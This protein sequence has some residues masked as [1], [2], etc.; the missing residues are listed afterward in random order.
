VSILDP[1][2]AGDGLKRIS[3]HQELAEK[4]RDL[5]VRGELPPG[6]KVP[7]KDLCAYYGVSR[8]PLREALKVLAAD[9]LVSLEPN[10]GA[11]VT[12][13]TVEDLEEVFPV[14]GALEAL[15]GELA[16]EKITDAEVDEIAALHEE[17]VA[18][19][20]AGALD[21]YFSLN[22]RIHE[23]ILAAARNETL[24]VQYR[25]LAAR[26]R[27]ARYVANMTTSRWRQA[28]EEHEEMLRCLRARDGAALA[29]TLRA[30]LAHKKET[31]RD[32]LRAATPAND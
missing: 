18:Q 7:E 3:L 25:A 13:I 17:M 22:Q 12:R 4:L 20:E 24:T 16:C 32:W 2:G 28:I 21:G 15:A 9:R 5:I 14:M 29:L 31:V 30:H 8:T 1:A 27:Q 11:W 19:Y 10:R 26:V 23:A 6:Q